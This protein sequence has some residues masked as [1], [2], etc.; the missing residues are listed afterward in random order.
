VPALLD[1]AS[2][3]SRITACAL[4]SMTAR[5]I[6]QDPASKPHPALE[7]GRGY[8]GA[9][10]IPLLAAEAWDTTGS[11]PRLHRRRGHLRFSLPNPAM[12]RFVVRLGFE[13]APPGTAGDWRVSA[14]LPGIAKDTIDL[15]ETDAL[16]LVVPRGKAPEPG[17]FDVVCH[18]YDILPYPDGDESRP[19]PRMTSLA[20]LPFELAPEK[21]RLW[22]AYRSFDFSQ[23]GDGHRYCLSGWHAP[24][25]AGTWSADTRAVLGGYFFDA[26]GPAF[27][28]LKLAAWSRA[29]LP[30]QML[31]LHVNGQLLAEQAIGEPETVLAVVPEELIGKDRYLRIEFEC[32]HLASSGGPGAAVANAGVQIMS[33]S[34]EPL[35]PDPSRGSPGGLP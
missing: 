20:L 26:P 22:R 2:K 33:L 32:R 31:R 28:T 25:P 19:G 4:A 13:R 8:R 18:G 21:L 12:A 15:R 24:D 34:I 6:A 29:G 9:E 27:L 11:L 14:E 10:L 30:R 5:T 16:L 23:G 17:R 7:F 3:V 1:P 35:A